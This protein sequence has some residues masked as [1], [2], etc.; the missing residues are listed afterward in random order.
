MANESL[1]DTNWSTGDTIVVSELNTHGQ[2]HLDLDGH[3]DAFHSVQYLKSLSG[4][5]GIDPASISD[6]DTVS[7]NLSDIAGDNL[8][9]DSTNDE[10]DV[11]G[12]VGGTS[13]TGG[14][15]INPASISDGDTVSVN[16]SDLAGDNL[17]VDTANDE[18][19][20]TDTTKSTSLSGGTGIDP[21]SISDGDTVSVNLADI[22]GD[23]LTVDTA[24]DEL[25]VSGAVGGTSLTGGNGI[26]P[27]SITDGDTVSV[28]LSDLAGDNLGVDSTDGELDASDT[29]TSLGGGNGINP[30]SISDGDTVSVSLSDLAGNN[31]RV[32]S[33]SGELDAND[34]TKSTSLTGGNGVLPTSITDG[35]TIEINLSDIAGDNLDVDSTNGELDADN[36]TGITSLTG[37]AGIDPAS[38]SDGDTVSLTSDSVTVAG[39][40][41]SLGSSTSIAYTDLSD[42]GGSFPIPNSDLLNDSVTVAG[43]TVALGTST[44]VAHSDLSTAPASAH[45]Q[46]PTTGTGIT[47][48]GTNQFGI[49]LSAIAGDNLRV[50]TANDEL[51]AIDTT[52]IS[53][54]SGGTG[55]NPGSITDG[56]TLS[57]AWADATDLD[58]GGSISAD[59]V[60][61]REL[62]VHPVSYDPGMQSVGGGV[63]NSEVNRIAL[64][65]GEELVVD[66]LELREQGGGSVNTS[67]SLDVFNTAQ[68]SV[69]GTVNLNRTKTNVG[70][71]STGATLTMRLTNSTQSTV[72]VAPR[73]QGYITGV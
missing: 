49:N 13:L 41:V 39:N 29:T 66:R 55:I 11:S 3:G 33:T 15:G 23:N 69:I 51:D 56:D 62:A 65:S 9:V 16:L 67:V 53:S 72:D 2:E 34:T 8:S 20:A 14:N 58:S 4:G 7:V 43:N 50:D 19:D 5:N 22:A 42:T 47:D 73:V 60:S 26:N 71:S 32:N 46:E 1:L 63:S 6:G 24:N 37:G 64:Q 10:L 18:L 61:K 68:K 38:I 44:G 54:L 57:T 45:H 21:A 12:A 36:T 27:T 17:T 31:L 70:R 25:D 28:N 59:S 30:D 40:S 35:D 52:G 48:E